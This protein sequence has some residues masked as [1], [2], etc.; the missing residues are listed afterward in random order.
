MSPSR[1]YVEDVHGVLVD[2]LAVELEVRR[3]VH[4]RR[5]QA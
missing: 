3:L 5:G 2:D 1:M 4:G